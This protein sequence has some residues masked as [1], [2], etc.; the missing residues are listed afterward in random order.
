MTSVASLALELCRVESTSGNETAVIAEA[1]R[2]LSAEAWQCTRIPVSRG[3]DNLLA[4]W[5]AEPCITLS[6]H[7]DTVPPFIAPSLE[8]DTLRGRGSCDAKGIAAAMIVAARALRDDGFPVA[9]LFVV[10]EETA[11]DG[12][13][14]ANVWARTTGFRSRALINGEPTDNKLAAGTKGALR[15]TL[16]CDGKAAHSAYPELGVS[17]T[18]AL[19]RLI[20]EM[21]SLEL[22]HDELLGATT[23]NVGFIS[24]GVADNVIAPFA[25]ARCMARL[26]GPAGELEQLLREWLGDRAVLTPGVTVPA[27]R[28]GHVEGF[29]RCVV[30]FAT[31]IPELSAWGKP[32]LLGPGSIHVAHTDHEQVRVSDL[33]KAAELYVRLARQA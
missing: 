17:A 12:A 24:G 23:I 33:E 11:H 21:D 28:L 20:V 31:D 30:S 19:A 25:E 16:R 5:S 32:Y 9:L 8:G 22:P 3:R 2:L 10:G 27:V 7:V 1:E 13:H 29:E 18:S 26:V 14:A 15:F 6:T 4:T